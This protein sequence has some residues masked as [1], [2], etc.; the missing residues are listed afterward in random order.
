MPAESQAPLVVEKNPPVGV[1]QINRPQVHNAIDGETMQALG[2]AVAE[3]NADGTIRAV[4]LT[5]SGNDTFC[6]GGDLRYF[7][8][9]TTREAGKRMSQTMQAI[10]QQI[11]TAP[12]PYIAAIQGNALGG[13]CELALACHLRVM[14]EGKWFAFR[15][16]ANGIITGWGGGQRLFRLVG[17]SIALEWLLSAR[18]IPVEELHR[19]GVVQR[20]VPVAEVVQEARNWAQQMAGL[21]PEV[22]RAFLQLYHLAMQE[23]WDA[24]A[25]VETERFADLWQTPGFQQFLQRWVKK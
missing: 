10:L 12:K 3:L 19:F 24:F 15:Q 11:E 13:G 23:D 22:V 1:I 20:V 21:S 8:T 4:V 18:R 25:Q 16:G 7:A 6:A 17:P 5:A 2:N 9:L 14:G